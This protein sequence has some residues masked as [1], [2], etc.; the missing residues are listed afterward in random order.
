MTS[1][2]RPCNPQLWQAAPSRLSQIP[3]AEQRRHTF[4]GDGFAPHDVHCFFRFVRV[5]FCVSNAR[6]TG[7]FRFDRRSF[8]SAVVRFC[9]TC[10]GPLSSSGMFGMRCHPSKPTRA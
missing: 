10:G 7:Q 8:P 5:A 4:P 2:F 6:H 3:S 9:G 1:C